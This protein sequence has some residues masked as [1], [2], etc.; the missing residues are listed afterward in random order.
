[1]IEIKPGMS[2]YYSVELGWRPSPI[3]LPSMVNSI[4]NSKENSSQ[5]GVMLLKSGT[6]WENSFEID[7]EVPPIIKKF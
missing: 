5:D 3:P 1:M 7:F 6:I 2:S 4:E